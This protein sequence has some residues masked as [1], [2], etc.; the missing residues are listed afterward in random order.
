MKSIV[1]LSG[2]IDS[3]TCLASPW[4]TQG[5]TRPLRS[6][7]R[8]DRSTAPNSTTPPR[9]RA[10]MGWVTACSRFGASSML[11][12]RHYP[13]RGS[14]SDRQLPRTRRGR[15]AS[16]CA[17]PE[18]RL[19]LNGDGRGTP[20]GAGSVYFGAHSEDA[21]ALGI[22]GLHPRVHRVDGERHVRWLVHEGAPSIAHCSGLPR[23]M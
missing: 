13:R 7:P 10:T 6:P 1:L 8:M 19:P 5:P 21:A 20:I 11:G 23:P 4:P 15:L 22:S 17:I 14:Q 9:L 16:L 3:T 2:G 18:R 12:H